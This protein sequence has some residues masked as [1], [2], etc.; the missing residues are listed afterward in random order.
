MRAVVFAIHRNQLS[1]RLS[2]GFD[3]QLAA[4]HQHLLIGQSEP[5]A[6]ADGLIGCL[7]ACHAH[8]GGHDEVHLRRNGGFHAGLSAPGKLRPRLAG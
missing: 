3:Y 2:G 4:R 8:N 6:P 7:Q 1:P 5:F